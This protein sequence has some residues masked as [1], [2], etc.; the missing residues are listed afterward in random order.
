MNQCCSIKVTKG[1]EKPE[2]GAVGNGMGATGRCSEA[3]DSLSVHGCTE[4][5]AEVCWPWAGECF[6]SQPLQL[7]VWLIKE[8]VNSLGDS[9][10]VGLN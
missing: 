4:L 7:L 5:Q 10:R 2:D 6:L 3:R 8:D 1:L 9:S